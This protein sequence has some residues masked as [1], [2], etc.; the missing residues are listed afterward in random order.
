MHIYTAC[1]PKRSLLGALCMP[2]S[3]RVSDY[4]ILVSTILIYFNDKYYNAHQ[5]VTIYYVL[6]C[7]QKDTPYKI[8]ILVHSILLVFY[9]SG[10]L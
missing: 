6:Y 4:S 10:N 3:K 2:D 7:T 9:K 8:K 1:G 5:K